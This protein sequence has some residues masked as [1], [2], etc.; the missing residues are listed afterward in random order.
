MGFRVRECLGST[1]IHL[2]RARVVSLLFLLS[3]SGRHTGTG[4]H[5]DARPSLCVARD[6][7][8]PREPFPSLSSPP[9][10]FPPPPRELFRHETKSSL[11]GLLFDRAIWIRVSRN[12]IIVAFLLSRRGP[13]I[14]YEKSIKKKNKKIRC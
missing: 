10:P 13:T 8:R 2:A 6:K 5:H 4:G 11:T 14:R 1:R 12:G 9:P 3:R 7:N